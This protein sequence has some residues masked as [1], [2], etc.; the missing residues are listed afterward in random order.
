[1]KKYIGFAVCVALALVFVGTG[2]VKKDAPVNETVPSAEEV[3]TLTAKTIG[4]YFDSA[5]AIA[6]EGEK[7]KIANTVLEPILKLIFDSTSEDGNIVSRVKLAEETDSKLTYVLSRATTVSD[8]SELQLQLTE[9]G[10]TV[11]ESEGANTTLTKATDIWAFSFWVDDAE[12]SGLEI[13][14]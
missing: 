6:P 4:G 10:W 8:V 1:M 9:E 7:A 14:F 5:E 2:C 13:T 3:A 11:T 12:K